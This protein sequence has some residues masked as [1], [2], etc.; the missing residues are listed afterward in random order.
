MMVIFL[1]L[2]RKS[3]EL[4]LETWKNSD[5]ITELIS[6]FYFTNTCLNS[7]GVMKDDYSQKI[8]FLTHYV[9]NLNFLLLFE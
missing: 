5:V 1:G 6:R 9:I 4:V 8:F 2:N 3:T 7:C